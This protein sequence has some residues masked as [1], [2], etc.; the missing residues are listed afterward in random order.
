M[1][2][3]HR[4]PFIILHVEQKL[5]SRPQIP[6]PEGFGAARALDLLAVM[7]CMCQCAIWLEVFLWMRCSVLC[8]TPAALE[9]GIGAP[10]LRAARLSRAPSVPT[11]HL[12][13]PG[14][15]MRARAWAPILRGASLSLWPHASRRP[16]PRW[17][18]V[19]IR[20]QVCG[21]RASPAAPASWRAGT[22]GGTRKRTAGRRWRCVSV[23]VLNAFY[24]ILSP[25]FLCRGEKGASIVPVFH[26]MKRGLEDAL[27]LVLQLVRV[28]TSL[29]IPNP[30]ALSPR[31]SRPGLRGQ[32]LETE[33]GCQE[34][35]KD[36]SGR[37]RP[38]G[39][40]V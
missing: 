28:D 2:C 18:Q 10:P 27:R 36:S 29:Q 16:L 39:D 19:P 35:W 33:E 12:C 32:L 9:E 5:S 30:N 17:L 34:G 20:G 21:R 23:H 13:C 8:V 11:L 6:C 1:C 37:G 25:V 22:R 40:R 14:D 7:G 4:T 26:I 31:P 24:V 3:F 38:L 15:S